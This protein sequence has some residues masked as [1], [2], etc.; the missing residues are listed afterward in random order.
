MEFLSFQS[1]QFLLL[2]IRYCTS[3]NADECSRRYNMQYLK[4]DL[5]PLKDRRKYYREIRNV[6]ISINVCTHCRTV[7]V[8]PRRVL[9][10]C[11]PY[12]NSSVAAFNTVNLIFKT[13]CNSYNSSPFNYVLPHPYVRSVFVS[14]CSF[15]IQ[16]QIYSIRQTVQ[17]GE[18]VS[19]LIKIRHYL[20]QKFSTMATQ[21]FVIVLSRLY[22]YVLIFIFF[23]LSLF[24]HSDI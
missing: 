21:M 20:S 15:I 10:V 22:Y 3:A 13:R 5:P 19:P 9:Y 16:V 2:H 8:Q 11:V 18:A 14:F 12:T 23:S 7:R 17:R 24:L 4:A 6:N 1:Q